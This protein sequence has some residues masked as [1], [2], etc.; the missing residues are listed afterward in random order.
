MRRV[1]TCR[2]DRPDLDNPFSRLD[3]PWRSSR[4]HNAVAPPA[5]HARARACVCVMQ[6]VRLGWVPRRAAAAAAAAPCVRLGLTCFFGPPCSRAC[7]RACGRAGAAMV[8]CFVLRGP[9]Q[10]LPALLPITRSSCR[11]CR[12]REVAGAAGL[13]LGELRV[14]AAG[15][16]DCRDQP[17]THTH[18]RARAR[19]CAGRT[20]RRADVR[21]GGDGTLE[22]G[23]TYTG[24]RP[25][26]GR[27]TRRGAGGAP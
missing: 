20:R 15:A 3:R 23:H 4:V 24:T 26:D 22:W 18:T 2:P 19:A 14:G 7:V 17:H 1:A 5:S 8:V 11:R 6:G 9:P 10:R 21:A 16:C 25:T 12:C 13:G 27:H